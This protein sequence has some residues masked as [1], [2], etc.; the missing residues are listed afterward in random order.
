MTYSIEVSPSNRA[1]CGK[2]GQFIMKGHK[3][4][5]M[6]LGYQHG[7]FSYKYYCMKCGIDILLFRRE[8]LAKMID[9]LVKEKAKMF[10]RFCEKNL[11]GNQIWEDDSGSYFCSQKCINDAKQIWE[12][13]SGSY[14]CS[15]KCINDAKD[16]LM[17]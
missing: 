13:D 1:K 16:V 3:R 15:Q 11:Y 8:E 4:M 14:F 5:K 12:D 17:K 10:C 7:H 2:C 6:D 9:E